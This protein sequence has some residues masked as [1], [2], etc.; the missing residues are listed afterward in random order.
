MLDI[1]DSTLKELSCKE[2]QEMN[3]LF[4]WEMALRE[5]FYANGNGH[6]G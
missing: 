2:E 3:L 4:K 6:R 1:R 5:G